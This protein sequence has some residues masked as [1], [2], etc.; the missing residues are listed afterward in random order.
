MTDPLNN[1][2]DSPPKDIDGD[3]Q[4]IAADDI[5]SL[6]L[7]GGV[8]W[9]NYNFFKRWNFRDLNSLSMECT[10]RE[11]LRPICG[12]FNCIDD[13]VNMIRRFYELSFDVKKY[14]KKEGTSKAGPKYY[15]RCTGSSLE[16]CTCSFRAIYE[17][18]QT[19]HGYSWYMV[20]VEESHS[21]HLMNRTAS[22]SQILSNP[23]NRDIPKHL[24]DLAEVCG[25][26]LFF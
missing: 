12:P 18:G 17:L 10:V 23:S 19:A 5:G 13:A 8:L 14:S 4:I 21:S 24:L 25:Y 16:K 2:T 15:I 7:A 26:L 22:M 9:D 20:D 11:E 3:G 1:M 6:Y